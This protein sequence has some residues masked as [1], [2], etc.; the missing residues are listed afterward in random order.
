M[1]K[2]LIMCRFDR[3]WVFMMVKII[4]KQKL[5]SLTFSVYVKDFDSLTANLN[6]YLNLSIC[7]AFKLIC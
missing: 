5:K 1:C 6:F 7:N 2:R 4:P 3:F